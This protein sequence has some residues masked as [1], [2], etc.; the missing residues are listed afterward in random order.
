MLPEAFAMQLSRDAMIP[1]ISGSSL[2]SWRS[3]NL[4]EMVLDHPFRF[5]SLLRT[6]E[7]LVKP[8]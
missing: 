3:M 5:L 6:S 1:S 4:T 2:T 8:I 7:M